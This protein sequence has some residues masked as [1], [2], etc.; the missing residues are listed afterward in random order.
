MKL[1]VEAMRVREVLEKGSREHETA[2]KSSDSKKGIREGKHG[3]FKPG[4]IAMS[5]RE[6][7]EKGG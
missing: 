5:V 2:S 4:V 7:L 1:Q 6:V 3:I